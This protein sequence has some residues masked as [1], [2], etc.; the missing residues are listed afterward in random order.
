MA[1]QPETNVR[2]E[3]EDALSDLDVGEDADS[4]VG[5]VIGDPCEGGQIRRH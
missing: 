2:D 5:G 1:E 3:D 4:V